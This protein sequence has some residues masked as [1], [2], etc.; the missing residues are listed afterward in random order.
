MRSRA[1]ASPSFLP[2]KSLLRQ[3]SPTWRQ[4][5]SRSQ[6]TTTVGLEHLQPDVL[7]PLQRRRYI[8][9]ALRLPGLVLGVCASLLVVLLLPFAMSFQD[10]ESLLQLAVLGAFL[11]ELVSQYVSAQGVF[12]Y[13]YKA[14]PTR[15]ADA[16]SADV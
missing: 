10:S 9:E 13:K 15:I 8:W 16:W 4:Q 7:A 11:G 5:T 14:M 2:G 1:R 3:K 6:A 12:P